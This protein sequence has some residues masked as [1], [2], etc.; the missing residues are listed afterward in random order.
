MALIS[1]DDLQVGM[2]LSDDVYVFNTNEL[3]T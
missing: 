3:Y 1:V 2:I